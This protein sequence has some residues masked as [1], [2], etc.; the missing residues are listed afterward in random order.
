MLSVRPATPANLKPEYNVKNRSGASF[1]FNK[2]R[3]QGYEDDSRNASDEEVQMYK[4][5]LKATGLTERAFNSWLIQQILKKHH[6]IKGY[7]LKGKLAGQIVQAVE[8]NF[9][10][11][12]AAYF[13]EVHGFA[14]LTVCQGA[15][16]VYGQKI[17]H[18]SMLC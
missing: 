5:G 12:L 17:N 18:T 16:C 1:S 6:S 14:C 8:A 15:G 11:H 4:D 7:F 2:W 13:Q 10:H 9:M 3:N